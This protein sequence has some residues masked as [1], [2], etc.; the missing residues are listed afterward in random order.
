MH[1]NAYMHSY[2]RAAYTYVYMR[3]FKSRMGKCELI[4]SYT[5]TGMSTSVHIYEILTLTLFMHSLTMCMVAFM[6]KQT[7]SAR[8]SLDMRTGQ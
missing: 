4:K 7:I 5:Y 3:V 8:E 1:I 6:K 2:T